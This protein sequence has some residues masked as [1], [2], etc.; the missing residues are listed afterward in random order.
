MSLT[1]WLNEGRLKSHKTS[2][3]EITQFFAVFER[4][5]HDAGI[6][7]VSTEGRFESAYNASLI[8]AKSLNNLVKQWFD[9]NHPELL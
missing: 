8:M 5:I 4:E 7:A 9:N 2:R 3:D 1:D 6:E